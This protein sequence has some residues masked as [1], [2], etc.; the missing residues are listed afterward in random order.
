MCRFANNNLKH[1]LIHSSLVLSVC[2]LCQFSV[3]KYTTADDDLWLGCHHERT[4]DQIDGFDKIDYHC[5]LESKI[6]L[7]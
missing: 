5:S 1:V 4:H 7:H 6:K 2:L 3:S